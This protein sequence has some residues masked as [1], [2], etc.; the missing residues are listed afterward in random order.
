VKHEKLCSSVFRPEADSKPS[1]HPP[2]DSSVSPCFCPFDRLRANGS[3]V[4][5]VFRPS[6][7]VYQAPKNDE[8]VKRPSTVIAKSGT[9]KQSNKMDNKFNRFERVRLLRSARNDSF[10]DFLRDH[11]E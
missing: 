3:V 9:T 5:I 1:L 8:V 7:L 11:Q 10:F 4:P 6:S 2:L